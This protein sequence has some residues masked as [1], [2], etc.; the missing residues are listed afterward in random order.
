MSAATL[1][2]YVVLLITRYKG[3]QARL[4]LAEL[5]AVAADLDGEVTE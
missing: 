1:P 4:V 5:R 3:L 2:S